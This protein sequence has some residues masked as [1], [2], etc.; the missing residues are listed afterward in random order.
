[1]KKVKKEKG[2]Y[3]WWGGIVKGPS[4]VG[5]MKKQQFIGTPGILHAVKSTEPI[6]IFEMMI[7][8]QLF[9]YINT[10]I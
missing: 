7:T 3:I 1:M 2:W 6:D 8:D 9:E 10:Q 4:A 5:D